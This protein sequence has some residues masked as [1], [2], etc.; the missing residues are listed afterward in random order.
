[1]QPCHAALFPA[2]P[3]HL[4]TGHQEDVLH[5][6]GLL[7]VAAGPDPAVPADPSDPVDFAADRPSV[8][9]HPCSHPDCSF[10]QF[11]GLDQ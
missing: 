2:S 4:P 7:I 9:D 10:S 3:S 6:H 5:L 1:L 11:T 8:S